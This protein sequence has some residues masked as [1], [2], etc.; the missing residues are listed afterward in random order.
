[1]LTVAG[2]ALHLIAYAGN[3]D[4]SQGLGAELGSGYK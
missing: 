4:K 2:V 1:M 3:K